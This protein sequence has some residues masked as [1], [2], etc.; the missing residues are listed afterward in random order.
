MNYSIPCECGKSLEVAS[1][2]AGTEIPCACGRLVNV[3]RLS[4]LRQMAGRGA[5]EAGTLDTINRM[6][7]DG[8]LPSGDTCVISGLPT[9]D[10]YTLCVQCESKWSKGPGVGQHL[11]VALSILFLPFKIF[12]ILLGNDL[13]NEERK[14]YG[15][16]RLIHV[17]IRVRK[18][19]RAELRR[20]SQRKL[21]KILQNIPICAQLFDE[22]PRSRIIAD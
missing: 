13:L 18:E 9:S 10:S 3:P 6:I 19:C 15:H 17:P 8:E 1:T 7:R 2:Q 14:E 16:D 20:L 22:F 4:Q 5:Y 21:R 12:W 11:F